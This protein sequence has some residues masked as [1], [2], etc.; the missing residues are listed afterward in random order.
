M[1]VPLGTR[2]EA[3]HA[4]SICDRSS[5]DAQGTTRLSEE[6]QKNMI[7]EELHKVIRL[8]RPTL[9]D[10]ITGM[11]LQG[12]KI[13]E[14]REL[15]DSDTKLHLK[16]HEALVVLDNAS[17]RAVEYIRLAWPRSDSCCQ[18]DIP[19]CAGCMAH[20]LSVSD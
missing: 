16:V 11:L 14:L 1:Q 15:L 8:S 2:G 7:G 3:P 13:G 10:R 12:L 4:R 5:D 19:P 6:T 18:I 17:D 9:A 20:V